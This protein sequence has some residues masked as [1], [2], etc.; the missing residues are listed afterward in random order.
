MSLREGILKA[1]FVAGLSIIGWGLQTQISTNTNHENRITIIEETKADKEALNT[2]RV[3][4]ETQTV[5]LQNQSA[6]MDKQHE[7]LTELVRQH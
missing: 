2:L 1:L 3:A 5:I 4:V 6:L 7:L